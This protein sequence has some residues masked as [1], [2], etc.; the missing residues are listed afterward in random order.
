MPPSTRFVTKT[1]GP[2]IATLAGLTACL[3][4]G[5]DRRTQCLGQEAAVVG[6]FFGS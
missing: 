3:G 4:Q 6:H 2:A 1:L 5:R